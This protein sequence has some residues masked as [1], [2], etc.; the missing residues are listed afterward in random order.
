M[1]DTR[2]FWTYDELTVTPRQP[3]GHE[4]LLFPL[5]AIH[6][7]FHSKKG[8]RSRP[9][10]ASRATDSDL[11]STVHGSR[12]RQYGHGNRVGRTRWP[13]RVRL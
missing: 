10:P 2:A 3:I 9:S 12:H 5:P 8:G 1:N 11:D 4:F 13:W 6:R 7:L